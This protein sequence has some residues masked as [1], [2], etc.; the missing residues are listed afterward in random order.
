[1]TINPEPRMDEI[2]QTLKSHKRGP[3]KP[4]H[5]HKPNFGRFVEGCAACA[6]KA[7]SPPVARAQSATETLAQ[8]LLEEKEEKLL[9][10][11]EEKRRAQESRDQMVLAARDQEALKTQ[12]EEAC[13]M[14]GHKKENGASAIAQ[15]QVYN[16]G[17]LKPF[18]QRCFKRFPNQ[19]PGVEQMQAHIS[20]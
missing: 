20:G 5:D 18:C 4:K 9:K 15:G 1:M 12:R 6:L 17:F 10:S 3:G 8:L 7:A 13:G 16:D 14:N 2:A 19:R 11:K